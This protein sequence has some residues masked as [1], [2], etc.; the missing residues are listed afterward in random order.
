[1]VRVLVE[2][3]FMRE[4]GE[5][6]PRMYDE[7]ERVF[8]KPPVF[9][10]RDGTFRVTLFNTPIFEGVGPEWQR[11]VDELPLKRS[12]KRVLL[13]RPAGFTNKDYRELNPWMS[14]DQAYREILEMV[15][16]RILLP[17]EKAGR[18]ARYRLAPEVIEIK[19]WLEARIQSLRPFLAKHEF[20]KKCRLSH[21][22]Q[23][24]A[25]PRRRRTPAAR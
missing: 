10:E 14:R 3:G 13:L 6:I 21:D 18:G 17:P 19:R 15:D 16:V 7:T 23:R 25:L 9:Q 22:V 24:S 20:L 8:L 5:G 12:Q 2:A 1:M 4:E 11:I